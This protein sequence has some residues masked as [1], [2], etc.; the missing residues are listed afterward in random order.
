MTGTLNID[1]N[2]GVDN[3]Y[4]RFKESGADR[5][6]MYEN[7]NNVYLNGGPGNTIFRPRQNGGTGNFAVSGSNVG[8]GTIIPATELQIGDYTDNAE[9][10]TFA[11]ASDQTG[12]INFYNNNSTEGASIRVTGGGN[13]V[14]QCTLPIDTMAMLIKLLLI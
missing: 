5:F 13:G 12:R 7:S 3:Y 6:T 4:L 14:Q 11:T 9:T 1:S 10:L 8:I 2:G